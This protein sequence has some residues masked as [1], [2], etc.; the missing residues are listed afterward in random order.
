MKDAYEVLYQKEADLV[1]VRQEVECL[2]ITATLLGD[3]ASADDLGPG[4]AEAVI[5]IRDR[6]D[7]FGRLHRTAAPELR[8]VTA[9]VVV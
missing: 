8:I 5:D 3:D 6:F 9:P 4:I 2:R 7:D 1:R